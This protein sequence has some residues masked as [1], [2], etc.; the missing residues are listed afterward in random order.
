MSEKR[1]FYVVGLDNAADGNDAKLTADLTRGIDDVIPAAADVH[2]IGTAV[3]DGRV[4]LFF[5]EYGG[6]GAA[7]PGDRR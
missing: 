5:R 2:M 4:L 7:R 3:I 1:R 6:A